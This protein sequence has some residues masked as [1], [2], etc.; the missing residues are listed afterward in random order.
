[1]AELPVGGMAEAAIIQFLGPGVL[2][3]GPLSVA[4]TTWW[5]LCGVMPH[6][7]ATAA[8]VESLAVLPP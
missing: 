8:A 4:G 2:A 5:R 6:V 7:G 3:A 1:M